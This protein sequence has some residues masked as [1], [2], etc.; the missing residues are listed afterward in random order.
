VEYALTISAIVGAL[1]LISTYVKRA[2][3]ARYAA[4]VDAAATSTKGPRQYEPYHPSSKAMVTRELETKTEY[5]PGGEVET[6]IPVDFPQSVV[7]DPGAWEQ[8]GVNLRDD[9]DWR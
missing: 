7:V 8:V 1:F 2:L 9:D 5:R 6:S 4:V 3:Q